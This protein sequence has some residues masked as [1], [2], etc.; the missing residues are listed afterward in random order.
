MPCTAKNPLQE[1][2]CDLKRVDFCADF[3]AEDAIRLPP[4]KDDKWKNAENAPF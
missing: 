1:K 3:N 4:Y 2:I